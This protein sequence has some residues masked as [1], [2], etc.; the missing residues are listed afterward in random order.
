MGKFNFINTE[1]PEIIVVEPT[2]FGDHRG[3][4]MET[5]HKDEFEAAGISVSFVQD[6]QS[7]SSKGVLRGIHFQKEHT[8]AKLVRVVSGCV[9]DVGVDLRPNSPTFGRWAGVELSDENKRQLYVPEG[10]GHA[11]MVL[12]E[13][14]EFTYKCSDIYHPQSDG[15]IVWNDADVGIKWPQIGMQPLLSEKDAALPGLQEQDFSCFER[16]L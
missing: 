16:W 1:V 10:F 11:F 14:A 9:F 4:F 3:Y 12:S 6:N 15:G 8:Q 13:T 7:M 2:V 5:Y